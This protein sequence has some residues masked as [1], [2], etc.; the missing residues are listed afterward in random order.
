M[1]T[2]LLAS[3][4]ALSDHDLLDR[5]QVLAENERKASVELVAHLAVLDTR[6]CLYAAG[7]YGSLFTYCTQ[8]LGLSEDA[9]C[10]RI[11]AARACRRFPQVLELLGSGALSLTSVR[12][13]ARHLTAENHPEALARAANK[14]VAEVKALVAELAPQPDVPSRVRKLPVPSPVHVTTPAPRTEASALAP[15]P[16]APPRP[17]ARPVVQPLAPERYRVQF[18]VDAETKEQLDRLRALLRREIPDGDPGAIFKRAVALLLD[19]V[20][21]RKLGKADRPRPRSA[22]RFETDSDAPEGLLPPRDPS[23]AVKHT[24]WARD[25]GQCA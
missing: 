16:L 13:I 9:A 21:R 2:A 12:L 3:A 25:G 17:A 10:N 5:L 14:T 20:E 8:A 19:Q 6:P 15:A 22:I 11:E 1:Y 4:D 18:T 23:N 7:G 24:V